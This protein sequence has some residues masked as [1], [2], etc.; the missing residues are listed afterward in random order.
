MGPPC[1]FD[2]NIKNASRWNMLTTQRPLHPSTFYVTFYL[3]TLLYLLPYL[4]HFTFY[5]TSPNSE[6][7]PTI[8]YRGGDDCAIYVI[9]CVDLVCNQLLL[10]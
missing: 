10:D 5:L 9:S 2:A 1:M 3:L 7:H 8:R 4:L 6:L